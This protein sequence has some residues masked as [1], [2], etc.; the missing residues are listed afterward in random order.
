MTKEFLANGGDPSFQTF[1][2]HDSFFILLLVF[3]P[4]FNPFLLVQ[5][6]L[7]VLLTIIQ[8]LSL[9]VLITGMNA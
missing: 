8:Q 1:S 7:Q 9:L 6:L 2:E 5:D 3:R 4:Y